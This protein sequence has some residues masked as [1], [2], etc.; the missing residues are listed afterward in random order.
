LPR[1]KIKEVNMR[2]Y[3][4]NLPENFTENEL[5]TILNKYSLLELDKNNS[6]AIVRVEQG[7][8]AIDDL[9]GL[10]INGKEL[11]VLPAVDRQKQCA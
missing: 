9:N 6:F 5:C 4:G 2:L 8:K 11:K 10:V 7:Q 1:L 3:L